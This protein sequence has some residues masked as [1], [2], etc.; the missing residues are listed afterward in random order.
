MRTAVSAA[1]PLSALLV[2][3]CGDSRVP[4]T[5]PSATVARVIVRPSG[6]SVAPGAT[7]QLRAEARN[8]SDEPVTGV[9]FAWSSSRPSAA[10]VSATGL[11]SGVAAG[12]ATVSAGISGVRGTATI[13]V[14]PRPP[15]FVLLAAGDIAHCGSSNDEATAALLARR[16]GT[17]AALGDNAYESGTT[18]EYTD[19]YGPTWG[20]YKDRTKPA[21]GNHDYLTP[22]AAGYYDYFGVAAGPRGKGYYSYDLGG[23]HIIVLNSNCEVV[24]CAAGSA[25]E[26]WLRADLAA[27]PARCTIGYWHHPR[28]SSGA[29]HGDDIEVAPLWRA[30]YDAGAELVLNGHEHLYERFA[31]Q[32]PDAV[33]DPE[34]GIR[35]FTVGTGGR[36]LY[37][38]GRRKANSEVVNNQ[39][40][41]VLQL[42]LNVAGYSWEFLPVAGGTFTDR[43]TGVC[44]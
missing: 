20:R 42:T 21:V 19:C 23:W 15:E 41:G 33:A 24:S 40:F 9:M 7:V 4:S 29:T 1:L 28:F 8:D 37:E 3:A 10:T 39:T 5:H 35:Q 2:I 17:V 6:V 22:G 13:T 25:Q 32:T 43:G 26:Q 31:P 11:V 38:L 27:H 12:S 30:L 14:T 36:S 44:H 18:R 16:P 34:R